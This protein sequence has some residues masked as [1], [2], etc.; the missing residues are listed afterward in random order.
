MIQDR[1]RQYVRPFIPELLEHGWGLEKT[2]AGSRS[3]SHADGAEGL[4]L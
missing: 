3:F 4:Y 2:V 1:C